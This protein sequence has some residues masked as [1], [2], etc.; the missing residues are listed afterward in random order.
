MRMKLPMEQQFKPNEAEADSP[1]S[2]GTVL[3]EHSVLL[4]RTYSFVVS[5]EDGS[6][7]WA[8]SLV[9]LRNGSMTDDETYDILVQKQPDTGALR[10]FRALEI[11]LREAQVASNASI[12][13]LQSA[14]RVRPCS[15]V[16]LP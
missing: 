3:L 16:R 7:R 12:Q 14:S 6:K 11:Y 13:P 2:A 15:S 4:T 1:D 10:V 5:K 8:G 9:I